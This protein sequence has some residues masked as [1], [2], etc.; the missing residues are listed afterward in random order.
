MKPTYLQDNNAQFVA[1]VSAAPSLIRTIFILP[2]LKDFK[3]TVLILDDE[4]MASKYAAGV[5]A[6]KIIVVSLDKHKITNIKTVSTVAELVKLI[7]EK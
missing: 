4:A 7:E 5:D 2:G 1:N 3:H 6:E